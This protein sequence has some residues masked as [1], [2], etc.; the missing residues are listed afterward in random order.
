M[1]ATFWIEQVSPPG[2]A[3]FTQIQYAQMTVLNFEIRKL[4]PARHVNLGWPHIS[5][6]TLTRAPEH[7]GAHPR[8]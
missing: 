3:P 5:V 2:G 8:P 7:S 1:Y 6:G 4:L